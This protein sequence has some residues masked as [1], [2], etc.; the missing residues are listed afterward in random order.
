M[1]PDAWGSMSKLTAKQLAFV[2]E[3]VKDF[4]GTRAAIR[5]GYSERTAAVQS[6]ENLRKPK[7]IEQIKVIQSKLEQ[8]VDNEFMITEK[9]LMDELSNIAFFNIKSIADW[10]TEEKPNGGKY[11]YLNLKPSKSL[12]SRYSA[13]IGSI[14][15]TSLGE[16]AINTENKSKLKAIELIMK[17]MGLLN[18]DRGGQEASDEDHE[19][20]TTRV[21]EIFRENQE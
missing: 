18:E 1:K 11:D 9:K 14:K 2:R 6:T 12:K 17:K 8:M 13:A 16:I 7:I 3:Y 21:S 4:N 10:G 5:A 20:I 15:M 19:A